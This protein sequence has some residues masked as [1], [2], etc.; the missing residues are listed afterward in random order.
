MLRKCRRYVLEVLDPSSVPQSRGRPEVPL[1]S[2]L[3]SI[4]VTN[5]VWGYKQTSS[6]ARR[7]AIDLSSSILLSVTCMQQ[8]QTIAAQ[9]YWDRSIDV[10]PAFL[11]GTGRHRCL[12]FQS[13]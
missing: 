5:R 11:L 8:V 4:D 7:L 2:G 9:T 13:C 12:N 6:A 10:I 3:L 1:A